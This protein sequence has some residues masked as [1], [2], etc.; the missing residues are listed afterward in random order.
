MSFVTLLYLSSVEFRP[1]GN[2]HE[3]A[4]ASSFSRAGGHTRKHRIDQFKGLIDLLTDL[5]TCQDNLATDKDQQND[6]G[7]HHT[8]D[9]TREQFRFVRTEIVVATGQALQT[10]GE[11]DVARTD[12]VLDLEIR[13]LGVETKLLDD[14]RVLP[15]RQLGVVLR[16]GTSDDHLSRSEN[17]R[18]GF[19]FPNTHD[20]GSE[21]LRKKTVQP[22]CTLTSNNF[23]EVWKVIPLGCTP[24]FLRGVQ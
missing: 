14:T 18:S 16:L 7:L 23:R 3:L 5:G 21:T 2:L 12:N 9:E 13:E 19:R 8:V 17:Q 10:D 11:L 20:H 6:L 22:H 24:H 1:C 4:I 15:G